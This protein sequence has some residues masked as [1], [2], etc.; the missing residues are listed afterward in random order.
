MWQTRF[1]TRSASGWSQPCL[2]CNWGHNQV[3]YIKRQGP[4]LSRYTTAF[5]EPVWLDERHHKHSKSVTGKTQQECCQEL[6]R[7]P[8]VCF[9][10]D[11]HVQGHPEGHQLLSPTGCL[12]LACRGSIS[13]A[14]HASQD[15]VA[16]AAQT[17]HWHICL[18]WSRANSAFQLAGECGTLSHSICVADSRLICAICNPLP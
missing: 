1:M 5:D 4:A 2:A 10:N 16:A 3:L 7:N 9:E 12:S 8:A 13:A 11:K 17:P 14:R 18:G 6:V 15:A